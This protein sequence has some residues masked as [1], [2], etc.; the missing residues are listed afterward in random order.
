M[1]KCH[2]ISGAAIGL[3]LAI[4]L[5]MGFTASPRQRWNGLLHDRNGHYG[6]GLD[7]AMEIEHGN[8][9]GFISQFEKGKVWPP[10][11]GLLVAVTQ[12]MSGND[13]RFA[14]LPSLLG[15]LLMVSVV[16]FTA[17]KIAAPTGVGWGAGLA[18][19]IFA[20]LSPCHRVF[21]VDIMLESLGSG[22]MLLVIACYVQAAE[23][24]DAVRWWRAVAILL[25]LLFFEKYNYWMIVVLSLV[26][27][28]SGNL[29]AVGRKWMS[30]TN[31]R[32]FFLA[33]LRHPL[34][35]LLLVLL[36]TV[37]WI[38]AH[39]HAELAITGHRVSLYPPNNL[40]TLAYAVFFVR[41]VL[42]IRHT[43]WKPHSVP[44]LMLGCWHLIP[45]A[46]SFL[47]PRRLSLFVW[48]LSFANNNGEKSNVA[49]A[50]NYYGRVFVTDYHVSL[51]FALAAGILASVGCW[52]AWKLGRGARAL[53]ACA[54][55]SALLTVFHPN[56]QARFLHPWLPALWIMAGIGLS[57]MLAPFPMRSLPMG[58]CIVGLVALGGSAWL[59]LGHSE[60]AGHRGETHSLLDLSDVWLKDAEGAGGVAFVAT[61][62]CESFIHWTF[63]QRYGMGKNFEW[64]DWQNEKT[65]TDARAGFE[66]WIG[67]TSSDMLVF[68]E[69]LPESPDFW[70]Q[71]DKMEIR[72]QLGYWL[73]QQKKF[74]QTQRVEIPEQGCVITIWHAN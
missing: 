49:Y 37:C 1:T 10:L 11:H 70:E 23:R 61:Q 50:A 36:A 8:V 20:V 22:L 43:G 34:N 59:S 63:R 72:N 35:W 47:L 64:P 28:E 57:Y 60:Q 7:M 19:L 62:P 41:V 39:G 18:A 52:Q 27:A 54:L 71:G 4:Y 6:Y 56:H 30:G 67:Q 17:E 58:A 68:F 33:E 24:R 66:R 29:G 74:K 5:L 44:G 51:F 14:V 9:A 2:K 42:A 46:I 16:Y 65:N 55:L 48:Y 15:W 3:V 31:W 40:F 45:V 13:W 12:V 32:A 25:T 73:E 69:V 21:A 38:F 53:I 26:L